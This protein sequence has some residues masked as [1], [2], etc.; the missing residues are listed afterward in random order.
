MS[1]GWISLFEISSSY[2]VAYIYS[3][4]A[5]DTDSANVSASF[6]DH[7][8]IIVSLADA[9]HAHGFGGKLHFEYHLKKINCMS[10]NEKY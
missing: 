9:D 2:T 6:I 8:T 4:H 5:L 10:P 1:K 3:F 7:V